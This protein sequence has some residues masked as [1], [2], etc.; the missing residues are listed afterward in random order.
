MLISFE[1]ITLTVCHPKPGNISNDIA[2]PGGNFVDFDTASEVSGV[3]I[4]IY[5]GPTFMKNF[6]GLA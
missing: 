3:W 5:Y 4:Q 2:K 1:L 6:G